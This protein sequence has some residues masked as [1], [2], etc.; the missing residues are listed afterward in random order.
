MYIYIIN[1][2]FTQ[3]EK[4]KRDPKS[5]ARRNPSE[6][7]KQ[8][9]HTDIHASHAYITR[10]GHYYTCNIPH[11]INRSRFSHYVKETT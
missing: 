7:R 6:I 1:I 11:R 9:T 4:H 8:V 2:T 10:I 3:R 5:H